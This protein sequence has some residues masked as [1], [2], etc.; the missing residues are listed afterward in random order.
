MVHYL[1]EVILLAK[2]VSELG[3]C[4]ERLVVLAE[5]KPGLDLTTWAAGGSNQAFAVLAQ[6]LSINPRLE[7]VAGEVGLRAELE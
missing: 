2:N 6:K 7:V 3:R 5:T 1:N 4:F